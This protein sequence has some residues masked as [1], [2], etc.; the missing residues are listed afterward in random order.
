[1]CVCAEA[2]F[3]VCEYVNVTACKAV[4]V[5]LQETSETVLPAHPGKIHTVSHQPWKNGPP[6]S[7]HLERA[8]S[9]WTSP[10][11]AAQ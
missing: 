6:L 1:M 8:G 11:K 10:L 5:G 4:C 3:S 7:L 2:W 9:A